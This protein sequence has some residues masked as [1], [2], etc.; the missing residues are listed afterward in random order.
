MTGTVLE[1]REPAGWLEKACYGALACSLALLVIAAVRLGTTSPTPE[2]ADSSYETV[3]ERPGDR[4]SPSWASAV[5]VVAADPF[6]AERTAP[7]SR[8]VLPEDGPA[9]GDTGPAPLRPGAVRLLGTAVLGSRGGF[10]MCQVGSTTPQV[11]RVGEVVG[12]LTLRSIA[13]GEAVF[14]RRDGTSVTLSVPT[15]APSAGVGTGR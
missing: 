1:H 11:V 12:D 7:A 13:R 8:Y 4:P 3:V 10:V 15:A 9:S 14:T 6:H 5:R 2:E